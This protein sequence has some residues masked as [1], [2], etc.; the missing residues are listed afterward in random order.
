MHNKYKHNSRR[1]GPACLSVTLGSFTQQIMRR[2]RPC[3]TS[4]PPVARAGMRPHSRTNGR[5]TVGRARWSRD[6]I[7]RLSAHSLDGC[8]GRG[9]S[10]ASWHPCP[11]QGRV[12]M[13]RHGHALRTADGFGAP[14][15]A[16]TAAT[17]RGGCPNSV[18]TRS[19]RPHTCE[20]CG[21]CRSIPWC[22]PPHRA[23][24]KRA[25]RIA[26]PNTPL[27]APL[28]TPLSTPPTLTQD[29]HMPRPPPTATSHCPPAPAACRS[30]TPLSISHHARSHLH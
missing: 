24:G 30:I 6:A 5:G 29:V 15:T 10:H 12:R 16:G 7:T 2:M 27:S 9:G 14:C 13:W 4:S 22:V 20:Y 26:R 1:S 17:H 19:R 21:L 25:V 11:S 3:A 18:P 23:H 8:T 28:S